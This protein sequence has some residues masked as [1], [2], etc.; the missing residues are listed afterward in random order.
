MECQSLKKMGAFL[1][2]KEIKVDRE[3]YKYNALLK[4]IYE[5]V[6]TPDLLSILRYSMSS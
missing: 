4:M 6:I 1:E 2:K 5:H 3:M